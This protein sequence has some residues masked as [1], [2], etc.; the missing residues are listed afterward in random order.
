MVIKLRYFCITTVSPKLHTFQNK[1]FIYI[2]IYIYV[3]VYNTCSSY[4]HFYNLHVS[5]LFLEL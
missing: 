4:E 3:C 5:T 2:D 1:L